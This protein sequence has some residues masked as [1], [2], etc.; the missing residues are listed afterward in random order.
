MGVY[1]DDWTIYI[2]LKKHTKWLRMMLERC[3]QIQLS[4]NL[5]KCIFLTPIGILLGHIVCKDGIKVDMAKIKII[6]ELKPPTNPKKIRVFLGHTGYYQKIIRQYS[7]ITFP[8]DEL[9][10]QGVEFTWSKECND[11]FETMK[12]KLVKAPIL[13]FPNWSMKFHVHI[14]ASTIVVRAI[15]AQP[16]DDVDHPNNYASRELNKA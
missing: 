3:R 9:L 7:N 12:K 4:L 5:K 2:P 6:I 16:Y 8:L 13:K 1:F 14:D 10:R 15:L 11:S